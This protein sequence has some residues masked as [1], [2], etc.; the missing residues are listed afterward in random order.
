[1]AWNK[2]YTEFKGYFFFEEGQILVISNLHVF[3]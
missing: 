1:M 2:K 3:L